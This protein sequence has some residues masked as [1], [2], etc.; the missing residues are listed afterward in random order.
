MKL[1][2]PSILAGNHANLVNALELAEG[3]GR[4]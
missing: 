4:K 3:D 2:A 1:L